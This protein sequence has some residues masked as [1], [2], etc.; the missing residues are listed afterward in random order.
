MA[1]TNIYRSLWRN[2]NVEKAK[3]HSFPKTLS[4]GWNQSD[5]PIIK[6]H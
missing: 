5:R 6:L 1:A 2:S 3:H 4:I